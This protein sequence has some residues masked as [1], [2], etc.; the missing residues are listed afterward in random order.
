MGRNYLRGLSNANAVTGTRS[1]YLGK[2]LPN[3][4]WDAIC[5]NRLNSAKNITKT[6]LYL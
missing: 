4:V 6:Q 1:K 3:N 2:K 5:L